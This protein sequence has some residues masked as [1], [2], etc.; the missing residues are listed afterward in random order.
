MAADDSAETDP[1]QPSSTPP[2]SAPQHSHLNPSSPDVPQ[3]RSDAHVRYP[4]QLPIVPTLAVT[5]PS[6]YGRIDAENE[7]NIAILGIPGDNLKHHRTNLA[8]MSRNDASVATQRSSHIMMQHFDSRF[9]SAMSMPPSSIHAR[10]RPLAYTSPLLALPPELMFAIFSHLEP[11]DVAAVS[12]TCRDLRRHTF[13]EFIWQCFIQR[14]V[15]TQ[16]TG[17]GP[18]ASYRDLYIAHDRL[19]FLP[20]YKIWFSDRGLT[21]RIVITRFDQ[22]RGCIEAYQL[23]AVTKTTSFESWHADHEVIIHNFEPVVKLHLDRPVLH[24]GIGGSQ[25]Q[26]GQPARPR[27]PDANRFAEEL[28]MDLGD[29]QSLLRSNFM[30]ARPLDPAQAEEKFA[31]RFPYDHVWPPPCV[32]AHTNVTGLGGDGSALSPYDRPRRRSQVCDQAFRIRQWMEMAGS[33]SLA[34]LSQTNAAAGLIR[35]LAAGAG[36]VG[37]VGVHLGEEVSTY[38]TLDPALYTP[39]PTKPWRGIW[40]GDYS[41]HGCEFLLVNQPDDAPATDEELELVRDES[42]SDE[43]WEQRRAEAHLY[44]GR[45]EGIKLTG[46]PNVPRGEYTFVAE[47]LG[48]KG[49]VGVTS[50]SQLGAGAR[51]VRSKGH[52]AATGFLRDKY[53]ETQ[54]ILIS[55]DRLAQY[56]VEFGHISFYE[57]INIDEFVKP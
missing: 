14:N 57:R 55:P 21:G 49:F 12:A 19:W 8:I 13:S 31:K 54:L 22:R 32:P 20:K 29:E 44:R 50:D 46:D 18:F 17:T 27:A 38:S 5:S 6:N 33:P 28:A 47:D 25:D 7:S 34:L 24:F 41:G 40:I 11:V 2:S 15:H 1:F 23:L 48:P 36:G 51:I 3:N 56:W 39:T 9:D 43:S 42:E 10:G 16:V 26:S 45:L 30:L 37:G 52:I 35:G 4:Q 53:L